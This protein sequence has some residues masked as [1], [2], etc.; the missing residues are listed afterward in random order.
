M[1]SGIAAAGV[2]ACGLLAAQAHAHGVVG[3]R[4]F[5]EPFVTE[6]VNP[7]NELVIARPEWD[8][9]READT[10]HLGFGLEKKLAD[11]F[12][13]TLES[14][15]L[16]VSPRDEEEPN[17]SGFG[18]LSAAL[19]YA[20]FV[21]AAHEAIL[22]AAVEATAP[23][24]SERVGAGRDWAFAPIL[25]YGKGFGDLADG[26]GWLRPFAVQGDVV[27]E[28]AAN[29]ERTTR[30]VHDI[31][32][33]YSVPY[34]QAQVRDLGLSWP[35]A[36]LIPVVELNFERGLSGEGEGKSAL[37]TTPAILYIDDYV[38]VGVAGRFPLNGTAHDELSWGVMG[39]VDLFIDDIFPWSTW[40]PFG[41]GA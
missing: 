29:D 39:I 6:D 32:F 33:Q 18:N 8:H 2:I 4:S 34:L 40:Q 36:N 25:L 21:D 15:W 26:L 35:L 7:K 20:F 28:V 11:R 12:S 31:A 24:G 3:D 27:L 30:F 16:H 38:E 23:T 37:T 19:K 10:F 22:S 13:L 1:R 5:I 9:S 14:E 17:E 41:S